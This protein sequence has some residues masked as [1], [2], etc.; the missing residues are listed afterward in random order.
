MS[1]GPFL[2]LHTF[3][4]DI[5]TSVLV[6]LIVFIDHPV[7]F[8]HHSQV[9]FSKCDDCRLKMLISEC[10]FIAVHWFLS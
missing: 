10:C 9:T 5:V 6:T 8:V 2:D 1:Y 4:F 7:G 3:V